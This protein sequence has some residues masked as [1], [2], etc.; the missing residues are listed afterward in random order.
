[1]DQTLTSKLEAIVDNVEVELFDIT[2]FLKSI[3]RIADT[4]EL[5]LCVQGTDPISLDETGETLT[6]SFRGK[7]VNV[8]FHEV[9]GH[10]QTIEECWHRIPQVSIHGT[11]GDTGRLHLDRLEMLLDEIYITAEDLEHLCTGESVEGWDR[12]ADLVGIRSITEPLMKQ[13]YN[14]TRELDE[15][16]SAESPDAENFVGEIMAFLGER[17][18]S[19]R[20]AEPEHRIHITIELAV[21]HRVIQGIHSEI[22]FDHVS[23]IV[24]D[25][26]RYPVEI[27]VQDIS[28][29][30]H[31]GQPIHTSEWLVENC[32]VNDL[33]LTEQLERID[34]NELLHSS[35]PFPDAPKQFVPSEGEGEGRIE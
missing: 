16:L 10:A 18:L 2:V 11:H 33:S 4:Y 13:H 30:D 21:P 1:M 24:V 20:H 29:D 7:E 5:A 27:E 31:W 23:Q 22:R 28:E 26:S 14:A 15:P 35:K 32:S 17:E 3:N 8:E 9:Y 6:T 25:G 12:V 34:L 19:A